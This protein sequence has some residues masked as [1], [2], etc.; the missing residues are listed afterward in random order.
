MYDG[1]CT[2]ASKHL[3][4]TC[5][6]MESIS[7]VS[8]WIMRLRSEISVLVDLRSSPYLLADVCISSY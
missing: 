2:T 6:L 1:S 4:L 5:P 7:D 3:L 8:L